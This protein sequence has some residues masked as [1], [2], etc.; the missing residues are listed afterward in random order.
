MKMKLGWSYVLSEC[1]SIFDFDLSNG[2]E[3]RDTQRIREDSDAV[4]S[5]GQLIVYRLLN[6]G[7][8]YA[9]E[10][11]AR[12]SGSPGSSRSWLSVADRALVAIG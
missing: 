5:I 4:Q 1:V 10:L 7:A 2:V 8:H 11:V 3:A 9:H 12:A 6:M